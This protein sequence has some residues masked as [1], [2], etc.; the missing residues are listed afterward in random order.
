MLL[1]SCSY[2]VQLMLCSAAEANE[3]WTNG[4]KVCPGSTSPFPTHSYTP[5]QLHTHTHKGTQT[6]TTWALAT[7]T[8]Q[9]GTSI[10]WGGERWVGKKNGSK[11][12]A[13]QLKWSCSNIVPTR[14]LSF[15]FCL[16]SA[17]SPSSPLLS[18]WNWRELKLPPL[19]S[20]FVLLIESVL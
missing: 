7:A 10:H 16:P 11:G 19:L 8:R 5:T 17:R 15:C 12:G 9:F 3:G 13:A 1:W 4:P 2:C 6:Y 14:Y 18:L 20:C